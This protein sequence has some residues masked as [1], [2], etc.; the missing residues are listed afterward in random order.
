MIINCKHGCKFVPLHLIGSKVL[1]DGRTVN[2]VWY[3]DTDNG[4]VNTY[5]ALGDGAI[6]ANPFGEPISKMLVGR[7]ELIPTQGIGR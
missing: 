5:D 1:V 4:I 7:V 2:K 6:R 3:V